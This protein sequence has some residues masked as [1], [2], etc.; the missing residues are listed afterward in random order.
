M[1]EKSSDPYSTPTIDEKCLLIPPKKN[2]NT[3]PSPPFLKSAKSALVSVEN[4]LSKFQ[5]LARSFLM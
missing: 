3:E 1:E 5:I 2:A 4:A